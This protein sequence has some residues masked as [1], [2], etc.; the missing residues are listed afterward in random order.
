MDL[1]F[2]LFFGGFEN[3][4]QKT[5]LHGL[6]LIKDKSKPID[7]GFVLFLAVLKIEAKLKRL[8]NLGMVVRVRLP[9]SYII[10][11]AK[12]RKK[13]ATR[14]VKEIRFF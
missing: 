4:G 14:S 13:N 12:P 2:G 11:S 9:V 3:R 6:Y 5:Q 1:G 10:N 7:L 8:V